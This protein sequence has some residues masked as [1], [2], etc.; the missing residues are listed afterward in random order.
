MLERAGYTLS[1]GPEAV[2]H[3]YYAIPDDRLHSHSSVTYE[4]SL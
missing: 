4:K 3:T 1:P 2:L